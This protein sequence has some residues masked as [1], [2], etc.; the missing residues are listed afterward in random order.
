LL[1]LGLI[2][3]LAPASSAEAGKPCS[4][5]TLKGS[6][7]F[8]RT[9]STAAGTLAAVGIITFDGQGHADA[10]QSISKGGDYDFD[11]EFPGLYEIDSDCTGKGL[12]TDGD[13]FARLVV[14]D[15]GRGLLMFSESPGNAVYGV[16]TKIERDDK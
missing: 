5:A 4:N 12:T 6:F 8:Y 14:V 3:G 11:V 7:G 10:T 15:G 13:E 2:L 9:G 16:G 1:V